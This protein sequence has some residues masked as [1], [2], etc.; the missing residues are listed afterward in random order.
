MSETTTAARRGLLIGIDEYLYP[1]IP[2]LE[3]CV[4]DAELMANILEHRFGFPAANLTV[5][6]DEAATRSAILAELDRLVDRAG[7]GDIV[8]VH[9]S[10]HGSQMTDR[11]GDEPD[12]MDDTIVPHDSG[13]RTN[14]NR[15]ISDDEIY[16]RLLRLTAMTPNVTLIFDCCHSG[17]LTRDLFGSRGRWVE[18]DRR[19]VSELPPSPVGGTPLPDKTRDLGPSGWLPLGDRYVLVA[20]CRDDE[21]SYEHQASGVKHGA[22]TFFLGLE[23]AAARSTTTYRDAFEAAS[24]QVTA[25]YPRQ[26]PQLEG[27][28]DR[29][30]FG[31]NEIEPMRFAA[32]RQRVGD[33]VTLAA[34]AAHGV[35]IGSRWGVYPAGSKEATEATR[36]GL[37][38]IEAVQAVA[39]PARIVHEAQ[40][41]AIGAGSRAVEEAHAYGEMR[42]VVEVQSP[43]AYRRAADELSSQIAASLLLRP[44]VAGESA[45]LAARI[46]PPR[47]AIRQGDPAPQLGA[48][49]E[50]VWAIVGRDGRLAMPIHAI[51]EPEV[52][53]LLCDNLE[54]AARY[55]RTLALRN[56]N[57]NSALAGKVEFTLLRLGPTGDWIAAQPDSASGRV[58][59]RP[60]ERIVVRIVNRHTAPLYVSVL[61]FGLTGAIGLLYPIEG[62]GQALAAGRTLHVGVREGDELELALP[63]GFPYAADPTDRPAAG[64]DETFKLFAATQPTDLSS[65]LQTGYRLL[66]PADLADDGSPLHRLLALAL[67]GRGVRD[68]QRVSLT[69]GDDWTT[70][71]RSFFLQA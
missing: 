47:S 54:R 55:R 29:A 46:V 39:S 45:D 10:G 43:P 37:V 32:V 63:A 58:I 41:A 6:R 14:P 25:A 3:G 23:F 15:D 56:P 40:P 1:E 34:G 70:V 30:L 33:Q 65:L 13:R 20:G 12:G 38:E 44:A 26:H 4:N 9:Y 2:P 16:Q 7:K 51:S 66:A 48:L 28:R 19:P 11:E 57:P 68:I 36:L 50:A 18:A 35:S 49:A 52:A 22:L 71:E 31:L 61:D 42:L 24:V 62:A 21:S 17:T 5:L 64:G 60:A 53:G 59:Y 27:A 67:T 69:T 8:V